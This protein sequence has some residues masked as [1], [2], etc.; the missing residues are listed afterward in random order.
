VFRYGYNTKKYKAEKEN[1]IFAKAFKF[2][3]FSM[4]FNPILFTFL[5]VFLEPS[6]L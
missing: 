2:K 5:T 6:N 1:Q 3:K 4:L